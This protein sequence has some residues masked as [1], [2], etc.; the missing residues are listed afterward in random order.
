MSNSHN[1]SWSLHKGMRNV[2]KVTVHYD[3]LKARKPIL[4][5]VVG[6]RYTMNKSPASQQAS[7]SQMKSHSVLN[8]NVFDVPIGS[9]GL[10]SR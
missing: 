1:P 3:L 8:I 7:L 4:S 10:N 9:L 6:T 5:V 2:L